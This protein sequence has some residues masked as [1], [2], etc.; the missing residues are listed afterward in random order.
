MSG[1]GPID[2][3]TPEH[4]LTFLNRLNKGNKPI[5]KLSVSNFFR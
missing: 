5:P 1:D 3:V 2:Q 4:I